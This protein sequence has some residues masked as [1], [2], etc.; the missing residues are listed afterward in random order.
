MAPCRFLGTFIPSYLP[1]IPH[2]SQ[3]NPFSSA[4]VC[5]RV[6][7][8]PLRS[9]LTPVCPMHVSAI[10]EKYIFV[11]LKEYYLNILSPHL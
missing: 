10:V 4:H 5:Q 1:E 2:L 6:T 7:F 9:N 3:I 8:M 11:G